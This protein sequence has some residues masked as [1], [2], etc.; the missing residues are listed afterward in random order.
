M[1]L[2]SKLEKGGTKDL[3]KRTRRRFGK[4]VA[5]GRLFPWEN[6]ER[7]CHFQRENAKPDSEKS[8]IPKKDIIIII[9]Y[10]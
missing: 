8:L 3:R 4:L 7:K 6:T 2:A 10:T 1:G 5:V 9:P